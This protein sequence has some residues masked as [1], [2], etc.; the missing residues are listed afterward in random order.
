MVLFGSP[1]AL[2]VLETLVNVVESFTPLADEF[3]LPVVGEALAARDC[4]RALAGE[5]Q[6]RGRDSRD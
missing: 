1:V 2:V 3:T 6:D 5:Q 4:E